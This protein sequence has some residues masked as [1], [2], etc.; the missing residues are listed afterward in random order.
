M[1]WFLKWLSVL[2]DVHSRSHSD[3]NI[4]F[5]LPCC[6]P[7]GVPIPSQTLSYAATLYYL[8]MLILLA[9]RPN[10]SWTP[11]CPSNYTLH[12]LKS[13]LITWATQVHIP[14]EQR[15]LQGKHKAVQSSTR[16]YSRDDVFGSPA[17][18]NNMRTR[19][20][21]G[22]KA[23]TPLARWGQLPM[24]EPSFTPER[25]SKPALTRDWKFFTFCDACIVYDVDDTEEQI[26]ERS[27]VLVYFIYFWD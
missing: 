23:A 11:P 17:L 18:Q 19:V 20:S 4:D 25:F 8:R 15:R 3:P 10:L 9:W 24:I 5:V 26:N 7:Y 27:C 6:N 22:W 14:E 12:C 1:T 16:L 2:D 21:E 13:T